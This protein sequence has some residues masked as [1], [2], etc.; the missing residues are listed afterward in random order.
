[1]EILSAFTSFEK[2][3]LRKNLEKLLVEP[4]GTGLISG[5]NC[6]DELAH[7]SGVVISLSY[8]QRYREHID[9]VIADIQNNPNIAQILSDERVSELKLRRNKRSIYR[10]DKDWP[11]P[12]DD[13]GKIPYHLDFVNQKNG[14]LL[15]KNKLKDANTIKD[16]TEYKKL[17][18]VALKEKEGIELSLNIK[19]KDEAERVIDLFRKKAYRMKINE[20]GLIMRVAGKQ[21]PAEEEVWPYADVIPCIILGKQIVNF[22][23]FGLPDF[24]QANKI[25]IIKENN[26]ISFIV[27]KNYD[28]V[29]RSD[30]YLNLK[31]DFRVEDITVYANNAFVFDYINK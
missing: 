3:K 5:F 11:I 28:L 29:M 22:F 12:K 2:G 15:D 4:Q 31:K 8:Q 20:R 16:V 23:P 30:P 1:M 14:H 10:W 19:T 7:T 6:Y 21:I 18:S 17:L 26:E 25:A 13:T 27:N 24:T 9:A